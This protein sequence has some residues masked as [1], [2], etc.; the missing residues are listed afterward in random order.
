MQSSNRKIHF[1]VRISETLISSAK[2]KVDKFENALHLKIQHLKIHRDSCWK[3][4]ICHKTKFHSK[5]FWMTK[6]MIKFSTKSMELVHVFVHFVKS[7][8]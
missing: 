8:S 1:T 7:L 6:L 2:T 4:N 5:S 3:T